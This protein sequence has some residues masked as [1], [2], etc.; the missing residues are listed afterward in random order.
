MC[1]IYCQ[2]TFYVACAGVHEEVRKKCNTVQ[3][4]MH[5]GYT[6]LAYIAM[7]CARAYRKKKTVLTEK[8]TIAVPKLGACGDGVT[9]DSR[10]TK[11]ESV[12][13]YGMHT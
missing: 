7:S 12:N 1:E 8:H 6:L 13:H 9:G 4:Y 5:K 10:V 3:H 2:Y 11:I